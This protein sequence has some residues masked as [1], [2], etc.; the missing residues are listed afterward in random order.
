MT[1]LKIKIPYKYF[2]I[3]FNETKNKTK[4]VLKS[5][6]METLKEDIRGKK[7]SGENQI[8]LVKLSK[9]KNFISPEK[10][11]NKLGLNKLIGGPIKI[12]FKMYQLTENMVLKQKYEPILNRKGEPDPDKRNSQFLYITKDYYQTKGINQQDLE[13]VALLAIK[14]KLEKRPLAPKLINQIF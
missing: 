10:N 4:T 12:T 6:K 1:D 9:E 3:T 11:D 13:K 2:L 8:I 5:K 7:I 14:Y